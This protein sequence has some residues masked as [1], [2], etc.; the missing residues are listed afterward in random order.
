MRKYQLV[1]AGVHGRAGKRG[2]QGEGEYHEGGFGDA[3]HRS[4][5]NNP[6][7][8]IGVQSC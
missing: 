5:L 2:G 4:L 1:G 3:L 8:K 6:Y 7:V